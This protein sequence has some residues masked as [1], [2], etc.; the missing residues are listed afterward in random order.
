MR[1]DIEPP[2][3]GDISQET[4][5]ICD[6][7][8]CVLLQLVKRA[9]NMPTCAVRG[10]MDNGRSREIAARGYVSRIPADCPEGFAA[11]SDNSTT[12]TQ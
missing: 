3:Y 11:S 4:A 7:L 2:V 8:S 5:A 12:P 9:G 6:Q 1:T 10:E